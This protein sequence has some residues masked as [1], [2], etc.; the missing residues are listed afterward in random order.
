MVGFMTP[1]K[2]ESDINW[3]A[4]KFNLIFNYQSYDFNR[5][6]NFLIKESNIFVHEG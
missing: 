1:N 3:F 6:F 4:S 2:L 5:A